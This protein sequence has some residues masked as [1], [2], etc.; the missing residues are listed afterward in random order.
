MIHYKFLDIVDIPHIEGI[1]NSV[2]LN[3]RQGVEI[4]YIVN[5]NAKKEVA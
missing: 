4:E 5:K 2:T 3:S 1:D